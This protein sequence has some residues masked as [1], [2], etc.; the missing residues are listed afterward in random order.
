MVR[1]DAVDVERT[2]DMA[3]GEHSGS[4]LNHPVAL[5]SCQGHALMRY[6]FDLQSEFEQ[7]AEELFASNWIVGAMVL[8]LFIAVQRDGELNVVFDRGSEPN[9]VVG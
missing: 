6:A 4:R 9:V 3:R 7:C 8:S 5:D 1:L 2:A